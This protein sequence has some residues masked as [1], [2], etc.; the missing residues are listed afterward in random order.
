MGRFRTR[1]ETAPT[2]RPAP[3]PRTV[4]ALKTVGGRGLSAAPDGST[5]DWE[6]F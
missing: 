5:D 4:T 1:A 2:A 6:E 3:A